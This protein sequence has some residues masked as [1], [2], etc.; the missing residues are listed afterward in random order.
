MPLLQV[1]TNVPHESVPP[2][3]FD[4]LTEI[5]VSEFDRPKEFVMIQILAVW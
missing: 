5:V 4:R 3:V 1:V 2:E